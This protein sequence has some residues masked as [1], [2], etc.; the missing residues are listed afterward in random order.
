MNK[1]DVYTSQL[2][3][4][5][6]ETYCKIIQP[7]DKLEKPCDV[8]FDGSQKPYEF[9]NAWNSVGDI[10]KNEEIPTMLE[11]GAFKGLWAIAFFEWCKLNNK[12]G[13][14]YTVTWLKHD[15]QNKDLKNVQKYYLEQGFKFKLFD[16]NSQLISTKEEVV[17]EKSDFNFVFI[18][19]D[20][21]Y[22][23]ITKD[24]HLYS[25]LSTKILGFHDIRPREIQ[26]NIMGV[27]KALEDNKIIF[28]KEF[29]CDDTHMGIGLKYN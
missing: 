13:E 27:Y 17:K 26:I 12:H 1:N 21:T 24:I 16:K 19:A 18:D 28:D 10:L 5:I 9:Y 29:I 8:W 22:D 4:N 14:Y 20:H 7:L 6:V 23:G 11:I 15:C 25:S 3:T 2:T